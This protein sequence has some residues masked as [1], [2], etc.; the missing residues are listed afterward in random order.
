[1]LLS[2]VHALVADEPLGVADLLSGRHLSRR[3]RVVSHWRGHK[4][5]PSSRALPGSFAVLLYASC[6][7]L[8]STKSHRSVTRGGPTPNF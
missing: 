8:V 3:R 5:R 7:V 2:V 6:A 1:M 4:P